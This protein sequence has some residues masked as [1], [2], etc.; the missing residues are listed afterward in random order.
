MSSTL[1][2]I[3]VL[4]PVRRQQRR[5][6]FDAVNS[7][8]EQSDSNWKL[9]II[10]SQDSEAEAEWADS[11]GDPRIS[12]IRD[13]GKGIGRA[14]NLGMEA[15]DTDFV[16]I[17][18]SDDLY[19]ANA[20]ETLQQRRRAEPAA[21]F[22]HSDRIYVDEAGSLIE[23][24][25]RHDAPVT[26]EYFARFGSPVK[27]LLCWRRAKALEIGGMDV[28]LGPHGCDD[29]DFPWRMLE[30]GCRF[31]RIQELLYLYRRHSQG[32]RLTTDVALD[33][34]IAI[35]Q[36]MFR[37]HQLSETEICG[38]LQQ[39][40][41]GYLVHSHDELPDD[42]EVFRACYLE[43]AAAQCFRLPHSDGQQL[44]R[45]VVRPG[46]EPAAPPSLEGPL[47]AVDVLISTAG[48]RVVSGSLDE[49]SDAALVDALLDYAAD[50]G[51]TALYLPNPVD[52]GRLR[53]QSHARKCLR[54]LPD[55]TA[56]D[57]PLAQSTW[58]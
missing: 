19:A 40:A 36:R 14:L 32:P 7:I 55:E 1:D 17:L 27:H 34:Q 45:V 10:V 37:K 54:R 25:R 11:F 23:E 47:V 6:F 41:D 33:D 12:R 28:S 21:D 30:A 51:S 2:P 26:R 44:R 18:L 16:S 57:S 49:A 5:F 24:A 22:F 48:L 3:T 52:P 58:L 42:A 31:H 39:A 53:A 56:P 15:A 13:D 50:L 38:Y 8:L 43:S 35:L 29:Y 9:L 4:M 20:I 46:V